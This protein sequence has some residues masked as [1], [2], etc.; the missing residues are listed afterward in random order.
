MGF[1]DVVG[2]VAGV[3]AS[4]IPGVGPVLGP[5]VNAGLGAIG[6]G[7]SGPVKGTPPLVGGRSPQFARVLDALEKLPDKLKEE[8]LEKLEKKL[9]KK[10]DDPCTEKMIKELFDKLEGRTTEQGAA[11]CRA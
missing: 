11:T 3:A 9:L 5:L 4:A 10:A 2:K 1:L 6:G 8:G 7:N